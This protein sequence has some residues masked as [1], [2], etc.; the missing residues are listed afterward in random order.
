MTTPHMV[1]AQLELSPAE[2]T[3]RGRLAIE[4]APPSDFYGWIE[5]INVLDRAVNALGAQPGRV[6][7]AETIVT[8][9]DTGSR[10]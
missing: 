7:E 2:D 1:R 4:G 5:L 8:D 10:E 3:I 9:A 6:P